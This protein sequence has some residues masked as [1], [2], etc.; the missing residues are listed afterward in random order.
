MPFI[1]VLHT[2]RIKVDYKKVIGLLTVLNTD[3]SKDKHENK[4]P[5]YRVSLN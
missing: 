3:L 2:E 5:L 4:F 1:K